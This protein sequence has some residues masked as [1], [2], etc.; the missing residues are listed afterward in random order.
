MTLLRL[1]K[2]LKLTVVRKN[3]IFEVY[4]MN[5]KNSIK[6]KNKENIH[7]FEVY[8]LNIKGANE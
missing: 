4:K 3:S 7:Y 2:L 1:L 8:K 6:D 5:N